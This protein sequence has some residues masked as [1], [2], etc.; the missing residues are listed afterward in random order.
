[1]KVGNEMVCLIVVV[2][3]L[4]WFLNSI[5]CYFVYFL[6]SFSVNFTFHRVIIQIIKITSKSTYP[7]QSHKSSC[8]LIVKLPLG[9]I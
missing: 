7:T 2:H 5:C 6:L 9:T 3:I 4:H 8:V 1:M